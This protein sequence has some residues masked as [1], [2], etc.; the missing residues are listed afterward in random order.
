L[1]TKFCE[2]FVDRKF[3]ESFVDRR[4]WHFHETPVHETPLKVS[5]PSVSS[6][7]QNSAIERILPFRGEIREM[8]TR[9][10]ERSLASTARSALATLVTQ[11][12]PVALT[13]KVDN[14]TY[15]LLCKLGRLGGGQT[16][17]S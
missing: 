13:V 6:V 2:S 3:C 16:G 7:Q 11:T 17:P 4:S 1:W 15:I 9:K 12:K 10:T 14:K 5:V 8:A